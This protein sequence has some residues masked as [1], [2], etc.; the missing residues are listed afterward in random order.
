[1]ES[2]VI[3]ITEFH[4]SPEFRQVMTLVSNG[5]TLVEAVRKIRGER[6]VELLP[7]GRP[8]TGLSK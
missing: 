1:M 2:S 3:K 5:L 8:K 6:P 7:V 4:V